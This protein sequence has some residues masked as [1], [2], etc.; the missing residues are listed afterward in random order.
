MAAIHF[1]FCPNA[2]TLSSRLVDDKIH[3]FW[4][5]EK[6]FVSQSVDFMLMMQQSLFSIGSNHVKSQVSNH[7]F[8]MH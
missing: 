6:T 7:F 2:F 5:E 1:G 4:Q 8:K 3:L